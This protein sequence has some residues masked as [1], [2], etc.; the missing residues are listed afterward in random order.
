MSTLAPGGPSAG[1]IANLWWVMLAGAVAIFGLTTG[2]LGMAFLVRNGGPASVRLWII[3]LGIAFPTTVLIV[4]L[5]YGLVIG[6]RLQPVAAADVVEIEAI[7]RQWHWRFRP[8]LADGRGQETIGVLH[9]PAGRPVDVIVRSEDVIH[10]FWVPALAGKMDAIPGKTNRLR[11]VAAQPGRY[12]GVCAE[13]C[14]IGHSGNR[15]LVI[16]HD[17]ASWAGVLAA[18]S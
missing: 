5:L 10:S 7:A 2:L 9:I 11:L 14:G 16:A 15:F 1:A 13:F 12:G 3:G 8:V 6:E 17:P 18:A 4:L